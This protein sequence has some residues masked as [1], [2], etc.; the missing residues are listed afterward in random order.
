MD[1]AG[2]FKVNYQRG[3]AMKHFM[4]QLDGDH[5]RFTPDGK[6]AVLDAIRALS[7]REEAEHIWKAL[8][9]ERPEFKDLCE[10][11]N[12]R[13]DKIEGVVGTEGWEKIEDALLDYIMD[14]SPSVEYAE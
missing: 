8:K 10:K 1:A 6:I 5:V 11:Y 4:M 14:H 9:E 12:F 3:S 2:I 7:A 13:K